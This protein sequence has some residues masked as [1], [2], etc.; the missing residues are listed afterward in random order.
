[1]DYPQY[2]P[3]LDSPPL[4]D[5][6]LDALDDL[7]R[8][9][10]HDNTMNVEALDGYLT[11][12]LVGP[13]VLARLRS[14]D[15]MPAIW[16]GEG[17]DDGS[18]APFASQ[19]QRKRTVQMVLRHLHAIDHQLRDAPAQW[20]PVFSVAETADGRELV[21][22]EEWCIGF[23]QASVLDPTGWATLFD[24]P[25]RAAALLPLV[26]L[27]GEDSQLTPADAERLADVA[28]RDELSRAVMDGVLELAAR[29]QPTG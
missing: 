13:P 1:M 5:A 20:Q 10:P 7:L 16:G 11:A 29:H 2:D 17:A 6:E 8:A 15:W 28:Q 21:D 9:L 14:A 25:E 12:L 19:K 24:A 27:G 18:A 23:L 22:A 4:A 3:Q 26:L